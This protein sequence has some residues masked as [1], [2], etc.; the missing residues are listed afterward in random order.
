MRPACGP[1]SITT[2]SWFSICTGTGGPGMGLSRVR[3]RRLLVK[4]MCW[5]RRIGEPSLTTARAEMSWTQ[6]S[7]SHRRPA[8]KDLSQ[9]SQVGPGGQRVA[10]RGACAHHLSGD[11]HRSPKPHGRRHV[12]ALPGPR[13]HAY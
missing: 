8:D 13:R 7:T 5:P 10:N 4:S 3:M 6:L 1:S 11:V 12:R 9:L 2:A